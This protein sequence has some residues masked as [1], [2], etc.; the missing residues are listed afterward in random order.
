M[1]FEWIQKGFLEKR[2]SIF[3]EEAL[4][5]EE[6]DGKKCNVPFAKTIGTGSE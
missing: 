2:K 4:K 5:K 3:N 6:R 1:P